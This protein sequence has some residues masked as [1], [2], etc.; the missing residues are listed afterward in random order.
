MRVQMALCLFRWG[1][2]CSDGVVPV[3]IGLCVFRLG[4]V[5]SDGV[6]RV[7]I[8]LCVFRWCACSEW[9]VR[10]QMALCVFRLGCECSDWAVRIQIGLC[11][12][13]WRYAG[14]EQVVQPLTVATRVYVCVCVCICVCVCM[15]YELQSC[16]FQ[17]IVSLGINNSYKQET[18]YQTTRASRQKFPRT[19][20][21]QYLPQI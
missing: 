10:V 15:Y 13:R 14:G 17:S 19:H 1:C 18:K 6:A 7:Q 11:V 12:F 9:A 8:G 16:I 2:A 21:V 5:C 4:C 3:Q 20:S